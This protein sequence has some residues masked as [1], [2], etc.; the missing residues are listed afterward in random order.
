MGAPVTTCRTSA[1]RQL[2]EAL[3]A[4]GLDLGQVLGEP[5][6]ALGWQVASRPPRRL[7][8]RLLRRLDLPVRDC[9]ILYLAAVQLDNGFQTEHRYVDGRG[10]PPSSPPRE[11]SRI[12]SLRRPDRARRPYDIAITGCGT[13]NVGTLRLWKAEPIEG[14]TTTRLRN[15]QRFTDA[16]IVSAPW[17]SPGVLCPNDTRSRQGP[18]RASAVL[19]LLRLPAGDRR[20][21]ARPPRRKP[22]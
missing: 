11:L 18:A 4:Y 2:F 16:S 22:E 3:A 21:F 8:P 9:G 13:K 12:V 19:L 6:A 5:D 20:A 1:S 10:Y 7:L 15:S 14:S 17:T